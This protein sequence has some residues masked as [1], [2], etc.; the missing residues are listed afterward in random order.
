[1]CCLNTCVDEASRGSLAELFRLIRQCDL[2]NP[3]DV[4]RGCLDTDSVRCD[5]LR[6]RT[7]NRHKKS[8][9]II[10]PMNCK[11]LG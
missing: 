7:E 5:Q 8:H 11:Y 1:M 6:N 3:R 4:S 10:P 2:H 9:Q